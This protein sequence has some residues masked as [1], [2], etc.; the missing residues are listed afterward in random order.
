MNVLKYDQL[1]V[2]GL[3]NQEKTLKADSFTYKS[4]FLSSIVPDSA[5]ARYLPVMLVEDQDAK[6]FTARKMTKKQLVKI[7]QAEEHVLIG[8]SFIVNC[9]KYGSNNWKKAN[10]TIESILQLGENIS[11]SELIQAPTIFPISDSKYQVLTGHRRF[12]ALVYANG[13]GSA[14]QFKLYHNKPLLTKIKQFQENA[15]REDL[16]QYGKLE[17]FLNAMSEIEALGQARIRVGLK[18]PT[19]KETAASLGISMGAYDN[20]NVLVR[21]PIVL[22]FYKSGLSD[23]FLKIKKIVL[24]IESAYKLEFEKTLLNITDKKL[25]NKRIK[26]VLFGS[27]K[28]RI[29]NPTFKFKPIKS[30]RTV[31]ALFTTDIMQLETG[32]EWDKINWDDPAEV[33]KTMAGVINFLEKEQ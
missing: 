27:D 16:P 32:I 3:N 24:D 5:N 20:Y 33:T 4:V 28:N 7:Y 15:C 21:Y 13:Y 17:S 29:A 9:L 6:L 2:G 22:D 25:I 8:K 31:K 11:V 14:A 26:S 30:A 18:R 19:V 1:L 10:Q 12:F 23:P